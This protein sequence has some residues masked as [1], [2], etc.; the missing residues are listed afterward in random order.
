MFAEIPLSPTILVLL[1]AL[2]LVVVLWRRE[3]GRAAREGRRRQGRARRA[4]QDA[5][6]LLRKAGYEVLERQ[7][8]TRWPMEVDGEERQALMRADLLV[9]R[10]RRRY[11]AEVKSGGQVTRPDHPQTRRQLLEYQ[12]AYDVDGVLLVDMEQGRVIEVAFPVE[13]TD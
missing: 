13:R 5:E 4:E 1:V 2:L 3:A 12:L 7:V 9:R 11:V 10:R 8:E 6:R